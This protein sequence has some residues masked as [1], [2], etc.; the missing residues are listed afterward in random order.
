VT[1]SR[2][3]TSRQFQVIRTGLSTRLAILFKLG[4]RDDGLAFYVLA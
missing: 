4:I 3:S 2:A 1:V